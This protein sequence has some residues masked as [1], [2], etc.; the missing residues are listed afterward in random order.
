M[1]SFVLRY[2]IDKAIYDVVIC[3]RIPKAKRFVW[4]ATAD[5]KDLYVEK[6]GEFVPFLE[7]LSRLAKKHVEIRL[8]HAKEP[9]PAFRKDFDRYKNLLTGMERIL[10]PRVHF[11]SVIIDGTFA[12]AGS[13]NLTGAGIGA[14]TPERR[15]FE[16]GI[17]TDEPTLV[18]P[19]LEQFDAVWR[20][21]F[22]KRCQR[23][24]Y[25]SDYKDL[26][27]RHELTPSPKKTRVAEKLSDEA[28][29][30]EALRKPSRRRKRSL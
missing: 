15:N 12:Y 14:K 17:V 23:K 20:G 5:I 1:H 29:L 9:G 28:S 8:L 4:I 19:I 13:A 27:A 7:V 26:S 10:C 24:R 18:E 30:A 21:D 3:E 22:C 16:G 2:V 25:C 6:L 11:K